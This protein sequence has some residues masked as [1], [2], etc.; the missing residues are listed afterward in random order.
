MV[1][2][3]SFGQGY[4]LQN[5]GPTRQSFVRS[6]RCRPPRR[7]IGG[8]QR[9]AL[10]GASFREHLAEIPSSPGSGTISTL[11]GRLPPGRTENSGS[12]SYHP[13][14]APVSGDEATAAG[15]LHDRPAT[16][17]EKFRSRVAPFRVAPFGIDI[18]RYGCPGLS[19]LNECSGCFDRLSM[20][21]SGMAGACQAGQVLPSGQFGQRCR[22]GR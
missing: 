7:Y 2:T 11:A 16:V 12:D 9:G 6:A 18:L 8:R 14:L 3:V 22:K 19:G 5:I 17:M 1:W 13:P 21:R 20:N 15:R 4:N 10:E